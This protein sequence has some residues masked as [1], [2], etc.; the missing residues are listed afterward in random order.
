MS[1]D[2]T[3]IALPS[4]APNDEFD[5]LALS[6]NEMLDRIEA[7]MTGLARRSPTTSPTTSR[8]RSPAC[9]TG[10][11]KSLR[12]DGRGRGLS[13]RPSKPRPSRRLTSSSSMFDAVLKIARMEA[14]SSGDSCRATLDAGD[15]LNEIGELYQP[16]VE[17]AGGLS[18]GRSGANRSPSAQWQPHAHQPGAGQSHRQ[19]H[20]VCEPSPRATDGRC[21]SR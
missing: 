9:V 2:L 8:H 20:Q 16:V 19:R 5:N 21:A 4:P 14:G 10:S 17:D 6:L 11:R 3:R 15:V 12:R 7:L 13:R 1:G 18:G